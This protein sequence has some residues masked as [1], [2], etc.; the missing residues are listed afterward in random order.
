MATPTGPEWTYSS[1]SNYLLSFVDGDLDLSGNI[2][3]THNLGNKYVMVE[4]YDEN[5]S[6][7]IPESVVLV[8]SNSCTVNLASMQPLI[9]TW[10]AVVYVGGTIPSA[11]SVN[12]WFFTGGS[13]T[14]SSTGWVTIG[15][16]YID[17]TNGPPTSYLRCV[18]RM[19]KCILSMCCT[20]I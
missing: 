10:H 15:A 8:D 20:P 13:E 9:G 14:T 7:V 11:R 18:F 4:V 19:Y 16:A 2:T 12:R 5:D 1:P 3:I 17:P 6:K